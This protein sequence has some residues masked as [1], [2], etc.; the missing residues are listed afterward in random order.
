MKSS[1]FR[2]SEIHVEV[3]AGEIVVTMP[4]TDF[5]IA[6][7]KAEDNRLI[8]STFSTRKVQDER[9]KV[10]FPHFLSLAWAAANEK[11]R[12]IGWIR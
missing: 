7:E 4:G 6:Y 3:L 8:A 10:S 2:R 11:A 1:W 9:C 5:S 12:E